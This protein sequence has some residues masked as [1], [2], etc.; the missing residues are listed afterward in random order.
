MTV[1]PV[2]AAQVFNC[3]PEYHQMY[4]SAGNSISGANVSFRCLVS[5]YQTGPATLALICRPMIRR[6]RF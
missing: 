1:D 6:R 5:V 3:L 4:L 2:L